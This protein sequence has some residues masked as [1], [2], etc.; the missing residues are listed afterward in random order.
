MIAIK[1]ALLSCYD[2]SGLVAFA[3]GLALLGVELLASDGTAKLL[4]ENG[5]HVVTV[6]EFT[7]S[8]QLLDGRVK[9]LHPKIHAGILARRD[10]P[11]HMRSI[12]SSGTIDLVVVNLYPFEQ[13]VS[14]KEVSVSKALEQ[15]DIGGVAL[16]RA[17]AKNHAH[18]VVVS[19]PQQYGGVLEAL[20]SGKGTLDEEQSRPLAVAAFSL[21]SAYDHRISTYLKGTG[22]DSEKGLPAECSLSLIKRQDLRYGENPHQ[23]GAWY[24]NQAEA[25]LGMGTLHQ[26]QGKELSYNNI[27]DI[28]AA[29]RC[30][31]EFSNPCCAIVKHHSQCGMATAATVEETYERAFACDA[32]SA[33]GGIV[34]LNRPVNAA[35]AARLTA[36]FLEVVMAPVIEPAALAVLAKKPNMRVVTIDWPLIASSQW[37]WRQLFGSWVAQE[38]DRV[39]WVERTLRVATQRVPTPQE[40]SDLTFAWLAAKHVKSNGIVLVKEGATVGIGQGQP[41]RVGSVRLA[42]DKAGQ[43]ASGAVAASDGFFPFADSVELLA[44]AGVAALIQPGGSIRD[45]EVIAAA[46]KAGLTMWITEIRHFRH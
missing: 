14:R 1:R 18:V 17:A 31:A 32:E 43:R 39:S 19:D 44:K 46:N 5:L 35:L 8:P 23:R 24:V 2:K 42:L 28:D 40:R 13:T 9:T 6:E 45:A 4:K 26:I 10:D 16:L 27:L 38:P 37:E 12:G 21:T 33:F 11:A 15:I 29:L 30:L 22:S 7:A 36:T 34:G 41:S 20:Q 25:P 3:K